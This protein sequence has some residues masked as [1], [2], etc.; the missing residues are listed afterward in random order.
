MQNFRVKKTPNGYLGWVSM[1]FMVLYPGVLAL[2]S[3]FSACGGAF[4]DHKMA[5]PL[6]T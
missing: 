5:F 6:P 3:I 2:E 1:Y 4:P